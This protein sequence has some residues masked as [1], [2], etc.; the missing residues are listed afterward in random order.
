MIFSIASFPERQYVEYMTSH[1]DISPTLL[2]LHEI[3]REKSHEQG[4]PLWDKKGIDERI[5]FYLASWYFGADA[6]IKNGVAKMYSEALDISFT[7]NILRFD[8]ANIIYDRQ[9]ADDVKRVFNEF[10]D[11]QDQWME[12]FMCQKQSRIIP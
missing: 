3:A 7:N 1:V 9:E 10:Y 2:N 11:M 4:L 12:Y 8:N 5:T 6:Y